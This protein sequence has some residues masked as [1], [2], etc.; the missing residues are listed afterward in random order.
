MSFSDTWICLVVVAVE[1]IIPAV[2]LGA[3]AGDDPN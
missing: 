3:R 2:A 1:V